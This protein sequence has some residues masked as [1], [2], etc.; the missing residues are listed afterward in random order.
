MT[1][2]EP[3][4]PRASTPPTSAAPSTSPTLSALRAPSLVAGLAMASMAVLSPVGMLVALPAGHTALAAYVALVVATLDIVV[5]VALLPVLT[6]GGRLLAQIAV[7]LRVTYAAVFAVAGGWLLASADASRF[8]AVWNAGLLLFGT[9]LVLV[10]IAAVRTGFV[11]A[12]I[13]ALVTIAGT[14]YAIDSTTA[15][16]LPGTGIS[17]SGFTFVGEVVLLVWL[18]AR[19]GRP[20]RS[21]R[22]IW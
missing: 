11:P 16:L 12:W 19:G 4:A 6:P 13:G 9:H 3:S 5:A 18:I 21:A 15:A 8:E 14:G 17:V 10:G 20:R 22:L 2:T 7:A 1:T